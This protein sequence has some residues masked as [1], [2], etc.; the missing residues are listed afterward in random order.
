[1]TLRL[2][3]HSFNH[4]TTVPTFV[5]VSNKASV[6]GFMHRLQD[7]QPKY[8]LKSRHI[9][10]EA[11]DFLMEL[12]AQTF[13]LLNPSRRDTLV[14]FRPINCRFIKNTQA[15]LPQHVTLPWSVETTWRAKSDTKCA[16]IYYPE[17]RYFPYKDI[18]SITCNRIFWVFLNT[19]NH[20]TIMWTQFSSK[21]SIIKKYWWQ[22]QTKVTVF[23]CL[24]FVH[25]CF[26]FCQSLRRHY[27]SAKWYSN[28]NNVILLWNYVYKQI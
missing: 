7:R 8:L 14:L 25:F 4:L 16:R 21:E 26:C 11:F 6:F 22:L 17:I 3:P 15:S 13:E 1:M 10:N 23:V 18:I 9:T 5:L 19:R 12:S 24:F 2:A 28:C 27:V 20:E